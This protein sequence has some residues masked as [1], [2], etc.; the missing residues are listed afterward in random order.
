MGKITDNEVFQ[1]VQQALKLE[2]K[3][4]TLESSMQNVQEWDSL[5]HLGILVALDKFFDGK[6]A[7]IK[8]FINAD[9]VKKILEILKNN[10][11]I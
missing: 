10:S 3:T 5:G 11:L 8:D 9:S 7:G 4:L 1:L 6:V 2:N